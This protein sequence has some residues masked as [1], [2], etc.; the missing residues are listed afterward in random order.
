M[1]TQGIALAAM[2]ALFTTGAVVAQAYPTATTTTTTATVTMPAT[3]NTIEGTV[4]S[5]S[6][7]ELVISTAAD[8]RMTFA[9]D[10]ATAGRPAP[11]VGDRVNVTYHSL[12]GGLF[13]AASIAS[14][15]PAAATTTTT[16]INDTTATTTTKV[17]AE[18]A[19]KSLPSTA[20]ST[21]AVALTGLAAL[22]GAGFL[23]VARR[24]A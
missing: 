11:L 20:S 22:L 17:A 5:S 3:T 6:A 21:P 18:S 14:L 8:S 7:S 4:V 12:A 2:V 9:V 23:A 1:K 10:T 16:T 24:R 13:H 19:P 15:A